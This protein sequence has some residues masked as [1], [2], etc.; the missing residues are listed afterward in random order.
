M[1]S[2]VPFHSSLAELVYTSGTRVILGVLDHSQDVIKRITQLLDLKATK[3]CV[4][5]QNK[6]VSV[7]FL[8]EG[9]QLE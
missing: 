6:S 5:P 4:I 7:E 8:N 2:K 9:I 1:T 3:L